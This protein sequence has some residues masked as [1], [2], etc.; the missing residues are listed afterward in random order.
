MPIL[1]GH[2]AL[3]ANGAVQFTFTNTPSVSFR[4]FATTNVSL[5]LGSWTLLGNA[6]ETS[7]GQFQ[8]T[9][10]QTAGTLARFYRVRSP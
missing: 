10:L 5:P 3:L 9:D 1:L 4:V 7:P 2:P 8:F 6:T